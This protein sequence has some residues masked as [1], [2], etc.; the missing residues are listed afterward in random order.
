MKPK[1]SGNSVLRELR[2]IR[3]KHYEETKNM[4]MAER[5]E[6]YHK[7]SESFR[8]RLEQYRKEKNSGKVS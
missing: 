5:M 3:N 2:K 8:A 1:K 6:Y 7:K 4:S